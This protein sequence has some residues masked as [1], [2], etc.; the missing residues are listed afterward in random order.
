MQTPTE[1][2]G[3]KFKFTLPQYLPPTP[4]PSAKLGIYLLC[5][6][7]YGQ[8]TPGSAADSDAENIPPPELFFPSLTL[9]IITKKILYLTFED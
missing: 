1:R 3:K 4:P 6:E 5:M 7:Q 9:E 2:E 8:E